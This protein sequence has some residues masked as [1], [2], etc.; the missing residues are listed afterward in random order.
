VS[1]GRRRTRRGVATVAAVLALV[2]VASVVW[3]FRATAVAGFGVRY[4]TPLTLAALCGVLCERTGVIDIGIE[5]QM[6]LGAF[7]GFFAATTWGL[8]VGVVLA[9]AV[10]A[11]SGLFLALCAVTLQVDQIIAGTAL[12][13]A[14]L[15]ATSF[16]YRPGRSLSGVVPNLEIPVLSDLPLVGPALFSSAPL[17]YATVVLVVLLQ[18]ALFRTRW[19]LRTRAVGEH[20]GAAD[21]V[22]VDVTRYRYGNGVLGGS[23]AGLG[24]A[25]LSLEATGTFERGM[26][27]GRGFLALAIVI[28]GRW[29]PVAVWVAALSFGVLNGLVNQLN[30][31]KVID[32]P[33]QFVAMVPYVLT[34]VALALFAGRVRPP[35]AA[36]KPYV[37]E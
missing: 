2:V 1:G 14:A 13:I 33:P 32:V 29:R 10:G 35:A 8:T 5:G 31:D 7:V 9:V 12:N 30:F 22:G 11:V 20:P 23:L 37:P 15:G 26:T 6:L 3:G 28:M 25:V 27:A 19:G 16:L 18:V 34:I 17:T 21:T 36:G 24:G 4:A